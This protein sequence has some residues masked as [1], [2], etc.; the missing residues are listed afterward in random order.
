MQETRTTRDAVRRIVRRQRIRPRRGSATQGVLA[1]I[2]TLGVFTTAAV[3]IGPRMLSASSTTIPNA[4]PVLSPR[5]QATLDGLAALVGRSIGVL[6]IH[7]RGLSPFTEVVLWLEDHHEPSELSRGEVAVLSHSRILQTIS[8]YML[9]AQ[10]ETELVLVP[11]AASKRS[12]C[13]AWRADPQVTPTLIASGV[14]DVQF[15]RILGTAERSVVRIG[16]TWPEETADGPVEASAEVDVRLF[17][18]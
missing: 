6:A 2:A 5:Q 8:L 1:I 4:A 16:L 12:F 3:V 7:E 15:V 13:D 9:D 17:D 11:A 10:A 18:F 14:S